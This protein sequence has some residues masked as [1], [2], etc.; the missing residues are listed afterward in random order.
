MAATRPAAPQRYCFSQDFE[1]L[2]LCHEECLLEYCCQY[3][4]AQDSQAQ[5]LD[6]NMAGIC[7]VPCASCKRPF[8]CV[9]EAL[10]H[11]ESTAAAF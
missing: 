2:H 5:H 4:M 11:P 9:P 10:L 8:L 6:G 3:L 1:C 7:M